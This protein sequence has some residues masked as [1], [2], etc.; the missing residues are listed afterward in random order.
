VSR[1]R[2]NGFVMK[3][4]PGCETIYKQKHDEIWPEM[5]DQMKAR[6]VG[7]YTIFRHGLLLFAYQEVDANAPPVASPSPLTRR[8]WAMME[9]YMETNDDGSPWRAPLEQVFHVD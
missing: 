9:P 6:G 1:Y 3:L 4:K 7:S 5:I 2:R 8:W